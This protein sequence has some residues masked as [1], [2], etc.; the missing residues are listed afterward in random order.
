MRRFVVRVLATIGAVVVLLI[1]I[2]VSLSRA[3]KEHVPQKTVIE[4]DLDRGLAEYVPDDPLAQLMME[5]TPTVRDLVEALT[6]AADDER[7]VA[8]VTRIGVGGMG[9]AQIQEVRDAVR[10]FRAKQKPAVAYAETFGEFGQGNGVY[11]LAT[12]FDEIYLQPSGDVGLTGLLVETPFVRGTLEKL[13]ITPR[14]DAR[15]EYKN[16]VNVFT[17]RAYTPAHREANQRVMES[18]FG[19]IVRGIAEARNF[20]EAALRALIDRGPFVGPQALE[21]KLV[22]ALAYRDEVYAKLKEK[23][24]EDVEFLSFSEYLRRAGRPYAQGDTVALIYGVG[25]IHRGES[26]YDPLSGDT[27]MGADTIAAAF[28]A[29]VKDEAVKAIVFRVDSPGGSAVASDVIW[30]ETV[31]AKEAG[32]PVI[33]SMGNVAGSGGYF[34][35]MAANKIV[36][37]PGTIT[38][39]IGVLAGKMVMTGFSDKIGVSW[40]AVHTSDN[41]TMWSSNFDFTPQQWAKFQQML[42]RIYETFTRRVAEGRGLPREKVLEIA[43]GRIW[44]GEDARALGLVDGLGGLQEALRLAKDAA[45]IPPDAEVRLELFPR[46]KTLLQIMAER[47]LGKEDETEKGVAA[48][49]LSRTLRTIRPLTHAARELGLVAPPGVLVMPRV[50][51]LP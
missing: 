40:D 10:A 37:Q 20:E 41:A 22:D 9:L 33:V 28:R 24:G 7:V 27:S 17:E 43:K 15:S 6:R 21:E 12:A 1:V 29:A 19:Q 38:G 49:A 51:P 44:T 16:A 36:A 34:V 39:S 11:Y 18:Q 32:K 48:A 26:E 30:R 13:G 4:I 35:A 2:A 3:V 8:V 46:K 47:M 50:K 45:G 14:F 23:M 5:E 25:M 42:D 31:R